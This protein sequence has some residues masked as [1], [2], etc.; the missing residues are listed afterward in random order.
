[1]A[2]SR[3]WQTSSSSN[4]LLLHG[5]TFGNTPRLELTGGDWQAQRVRLS[6][7]ARDPSRRASLPDAGLRL[8]GIRHCAAV[9]WTKTVF[10]RCLN[11]TTGLVTQW[12][13]G[14]KHLQTRLPWEPHASRKNSAY[15]LISSRNCSPAERL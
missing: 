14:E 12:Q 1:F 6:A 8:A 4:C 3:K 11:V 5:S 9:S 13:H 2:K 7:R 15:A 10:A